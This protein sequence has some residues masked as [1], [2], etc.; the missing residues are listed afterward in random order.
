L[1]TTFLHSCLLDQSNCSFTPVK[2]NLSTYNLHTMPTSKHRA[3]SPEDAS[4]A[5][6]ACRKA[7]DNI[8]AMQ[9][10]QDLDNEGK[11]KKILSAQRRENE[12][13]ANKR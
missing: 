5:K 13:S 4:R 10:Q 9:L 6:K 2:R 3:S 8:Y 11:D 12:E 7:D 1:L